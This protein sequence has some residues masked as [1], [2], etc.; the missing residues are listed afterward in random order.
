MSLSLQEKVGGKGSENRAKLLYTRPDVIQAL[1]SQPK[2]HTT[3]TM[4]FI[5]NV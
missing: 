3:A 4:R 1:E 5:V 2:R